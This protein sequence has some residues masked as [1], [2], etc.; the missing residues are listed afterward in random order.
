MA[1]LED[2]FDAR[3]HLLVLLQ[4]RRALGRQHRDAVAAQARCAEDPDVESTWSPVAEV[5][6]SDHHDLA[7]ALDNTAL[8][9]ET[10]GD[11]IWTPLALGSA[12]GG[13]SARSGRLAAYRNSWV[14][15]TVEG[16]TSLYFLWRVASEAG[17]D[18]LVFSL[19]G[20][21][22]RR[23]WKR[24]R[25]DDYRDDIGR[26]QAHGIAVNG[27]FVLGLD[28]DGP[29]V[30]DAVE[31]FVRESGQFDVQ[32]TV[33]TPFPGTPLY[34]RLRREGRLLE[35][36]A[37][38]RCSL[39]DVNYVP[40]KMSAAELQRGLLGLAQRLYTEDERG[41]RQDRFR[42]QRRRHR[43]SLLAGVSA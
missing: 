2:A 30:F 6:V 12:A 15:T 40:R 9:W 34:E 38:E 21:E 36:G 10:G 23:N 16:P 33:M 1:L 5:V 13:D 41:A 7:E 4:Q 35:E 19:D 37:W 20:V 43:R 39:F 28:G 17:R 8:E 24:T 18:R 27:C 32:I 25:F 29:E 26:I 3:P 31:A 22:Q 42:K 11:A 14:E